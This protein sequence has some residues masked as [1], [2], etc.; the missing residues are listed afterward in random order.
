MF[1]VAD[2]EAALGIEGV[3]FEDVGDEFGLV[4]AGAVEFAAFDGGEVAFKVEVGGDA[5][6]EDGG[7]RG[8]DVEGPAPGRKAFKE[9]RDVGEDFVLEEA[10]YREVFAVAQ[11]GFVGLGAVETVEAH[12]GF[13]EGRPDEGVEPGTLRL[14]D[15]EVGE[16]VANGVRYAQTRVG[17][18]AVEVKEEGVEGGVH[19]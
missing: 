14:F 17:K 5:A 10:C 16:A 19:G 9:G 1:A 6:G 7:L 12:E 13:L 11:A 15:A 3:F 8:G 18:G 2:H 4:G